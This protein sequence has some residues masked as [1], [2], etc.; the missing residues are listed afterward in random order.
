MT[1][2]VGGEQTKTTPS[3]IIIP[4]AE[5]PK[6]ASGNSVLV[7]TKK[8]QEILNGMGFARIP[9][10]PSIHAFLSQTGVLVLAKVV[11]G[12]YGEMEMHTNLDISPKKGKEK[13]VIPM[14]LFSR[15]QQTSYV[16]F[17]PFLV[18]VENFNN[19]ANPVMPWTESPRTEAADFQDVLDWVIENMPYAD[20]KFFGESGQTL[21]K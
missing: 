3:S 21:T 11:N 10:M 4:A 17:G 1:T 6:Q 9:S 5:Q 8:I 13:C 2:L 12:V 20:S 14:S 15:D 19:R 7:D 18:K 16:G